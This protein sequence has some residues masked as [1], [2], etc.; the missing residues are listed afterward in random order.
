MT[1]ILQN[2]PF[3]TESLLVLTEGIRVVMNFSDDSLTNA[4]T[5][6]A[7]AP[8]VATTENPVSKTVLLAEDEPM[9]RDLITLFLNNLGYVVHSAENGQDLLKVAEETTPDGF[10]GGTV[11]PDRFDASPEKIGELEINIQR[12]GI[13]GNLVANNHRSATILIPLLSTNP[14]TGER[15]NYYRFVIA[16]SLYLHL[17]YT[18][19]NH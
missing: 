17:C 15:L 8:A 5:T 14:K 13:I 10:D 19:S 9:I 12:S 18:F 4:G 2:R 11:I 7:P 6:L 1:G 3:S 16:R